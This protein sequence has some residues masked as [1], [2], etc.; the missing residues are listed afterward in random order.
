MA[1]ATSYNPEVP[2]VRKVMV[3]LLTVSLASG[4]GI[5]LG[6]SALAA[7]P[8]DTPAAALSQDDAPG[9]TNSPTPRRQTTRP[10]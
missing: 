1:L 3:G 9:V 2:L 7:P 5:S 4:M 8:A 10:A 6:P